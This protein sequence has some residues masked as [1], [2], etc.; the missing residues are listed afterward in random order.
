MP[1]MMLNTSGRSPTTCQRLEYELVLL[2]LWVFYQANKFIWDNK[3]LHHQQHLMSIFPLCGDGQYIL[4]DALCCAGS[5]CDVKNSSVFFD[6]FLHV[7]R[8]LP[9]TGN[10]NVL[11]RQ[12]ICSLLAT[13]PHSQSALPHHLSHPYQAHWLEE[14]FISLSFTYWCSAHP[15]DHPHLSFS[16]RSMLDDFCPCLDTIGHAFLHIGIIHLPFYFYWGCPWGEKGREFTKFL[17]GTLDPCGHV[18]CLT[19][20]GS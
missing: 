17:P 5:V 6:S 3:G 12:C 10:F 2:F 20:F 19:S 15:P 14:V 7:L 18:C 16:F 1:E 4:F 9:A 11:W 13:C 8:G